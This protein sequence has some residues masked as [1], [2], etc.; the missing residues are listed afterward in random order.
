MNNSSQQL[1][2]PTAVVVLIIIIGVVVT[3]GVYLLND[4][5]QTNILNNGSIVVNGQ[6]YLNGQRVID[7]KNGFSAVAPDGWGYEYSYVDSINTVK[8]GSPAQIFTL[9]PEDR[10]NEYGGPVI[11][12]STFTIDER[13]SAKDVAN[14]VHDMNIADKIVEGTRECY[15]VSGINNIIGMDYYAYRSD[16]TDL[17]KCDDEGTE[18]GVS[19]TV[20]FKNV[21][22]P[23][24][25]TITFG[26]NKNNFE[27]YSTSFMN[28]I[29][30]LSYQG[31]EM[32]FIN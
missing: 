8:F 22:D 27:N 30:S 23:N 17:T 21:D 4:K 16:N 9:E 5:P 26:G 1:N 28:F 15:F 20:I 11:T 32:G 6:D 18:I 12:I 7:F 31:N 29:S 3:G 25:L 10:Q 19:E 14:L 24:V 2:K 13:L